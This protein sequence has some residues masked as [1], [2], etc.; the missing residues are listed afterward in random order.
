MLVFQGL[1]G[2]YFEER[3]EILVSSIAIKHSPR[4]NPLYT[5]VPLNLTL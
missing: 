2:E 1:P 4:D 5:R 3:N